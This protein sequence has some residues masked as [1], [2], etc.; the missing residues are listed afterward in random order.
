MQVGE[1]AVLRHCGRCRL[2]ET[3]QTGMVV[4]GVVVVEVGKTGVRV[5]RGGALLVRGQRV[6]VWAVVEDRAGIGAGG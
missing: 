2:V 4:Q 5:E 3:G 6:G 1:A